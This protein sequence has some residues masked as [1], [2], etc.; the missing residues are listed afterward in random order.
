ML[1]FWRFKMLHPATVQG[2][3][4][5]VHE[6]QYWT[7]NITKDDWAADGRLRNGGKLLSIHVRERVGVEG[8]SISKWGARGLSFLGKM[9]LSF[10][11]YFYPYCFL[12]DGWNG[13]REFGRLE[14]AAF[15]RPSLLA[16][17][18]FCVNRIPLLPIS[19]WPWKG[20]CPEE[21]SP[22]KRDDMSGTMFVNNR[23]FSNSSVWGVN[24][25]AWTENNRKSSEQVIFANQ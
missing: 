23:D 10:L 6:E 5:M 16:K 17:T 9:A 22:S 8:Q 11:L 7:G 21:I 18:T 20:C 13:L 24:T 4:R 12:S 2:L 1:F 19:I 15:Q 3:F 25:T 14:M